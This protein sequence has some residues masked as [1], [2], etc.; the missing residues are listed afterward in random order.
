M[1]KKVVGDIAIQVGADIS[2]LQKQMGKG[3]KIIKGF[4]GDTAAM[5]K[6]IAKAGAVV[7]TTAVAMGAG[8]LAASKN[9][10][11]AAVEINNLSKVAN[12]GT[13]EFQKMAAAT[14]TVNINQEKLSDILKD[15][16]DRVGDFVTTGG[17]PMKDFFEQIAPLV[18]V[19]AD[20]FARLSGPEALQ[21]YYD[22]L[23]KANL[24]QQEMTF[25][26]EAMASD[27]TALIPLL[28]NGGAEIKRLGDE[29]QR[30]G[31]IIDDD[32][33]QNGVE[34]DR[35]IG[36]AADT[37]S[38][39]FNKALLENADQ[40]ANVAQVISE[41]LIPAAGDLVTKIGEVVDAV[42]EGAGAV[43]DFFNLA[44]GTTDSEG[45]YTN[46]DGIYT[47]PVDDGDG[48]SSTSGT[49]ILDA[50][51]NPVFDE[52]AAGGGGFTGNGGGSTS[53]LSEDDL[54]KLQESYETEAEIIDNKM[55]T[56]LERLQ[57]FRERKLG[58]EEEYNDLEARITKEHQ[59][60]MTRLDQ[61]A[62]NSKLNVARSV[63]NG[64]SSLMQS[65]NEK[66]FK[67]G[68]AAAIANAVVNTWQGVSRAI[69]DYPYPYSLAVAAAV[70]AKG[71]ATVSSIQS[72]TIGGGSTTGGGASGGG[73]VA[74]AGGGQSQDGGNT[75][76]NVSIT[77]D[78]FSAS[79]LRGLL[80]S[81]NEHLEDGGRVRIV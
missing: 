28:R 66:L 32:L 35:V 20:Q 62:M 76:V 37:I 67:I 46:K 11:A 38:T 33:I 22:S 5:S 56:D 17:G 58:T 60:A 8:L 79:G 19:T 34:L 68:K 13:V 4:G 49:Y 9:A 43:S 3:S 75:L 74:D 7:A 80:E 15:V 61:E 24:S 50:D 14:S 21:L 40:I 70:A 64:L 78:N 29:A 81:L 42:T 71:F 30:S 39:S 12:A 18:G 6:K 59:D 27:T 47:G 23:E 54:E 52:P 77:G 69:A 41:T 10:A 73:A 2:P 45:T 16:N 72:Q 44:R 1:A 25:F 53:T 63:F 31:R 48:A 55:A 51:G 57:E 26:L 65:E 36:D